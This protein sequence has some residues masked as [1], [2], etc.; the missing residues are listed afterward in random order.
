M[1]AL[2][3]GEID[4][5]LESICGDIEEPLYTASGKKVLPFDFK[6]Q[7]TYTNDH[8]ATLEIIHRELAQHLSA[9]FSAYLK[10]TVHIEEI[11]IRP[12]THEAFQ[13]PLNRPCCL[14][15]INLHPLKGSV[16]IKVGPEA[17]GSIL[18]IVFGGSGKIHY[19]K[20]P[21]D[22]TNLEKFVMEKLLPGF[23]IGIRRSW[24]KVIEL[25]P[26]LTAIETRMQ[27]VQ[28]APSTE[29]GIVAMFLC[30]INDALPDHISIYYP[31]H[32]LE[33]IKTKLTSHYYNS[34]VET[35]NEPAKAAPEPGSV[36]VSIIIDEKNFQLKTINDL[37]IGAILELDKTIDKPM[38]IYANGVMVARG[39][40]VVIG[41]QFGIKITELKE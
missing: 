40:V 10:S 16:V 22:L 41:D 14:A 8:L 30:N 15:V 2:S 6:R 3:Q 27:S 12:Y 39:E 36:P 20:H 11:L 5:I 19:R 23:F 33:P 26:E 17:S 13:S 38:D 34:G 25:T 37:E 29:M 24:K 21:A 32:V 9:Y 28:I 4:Q 7:V 35:V 31:C 18:D 1:E